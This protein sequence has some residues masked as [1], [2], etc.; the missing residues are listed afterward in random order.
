MEGIHPKRKRDKLNP[1]TLTKTNGQF[2]ISFK[3]GQGYEHTVE[4][5]E[6]IYK[7]FNEFELE[8]ISHINVISRHYEQS[9]LTE[10]TLYQRTLFKPLPIDEELAKK[11]QI[12][13]LHAAISALPDIQRKR[14]WMYYFQGLT[15]DEISKKEG[16]TIMPI[17]RSIDR[18]MIKIKKHLE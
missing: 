6:D 9:E 2:Y 11:I 8:D 10:C 16:C 3:D 5:S 13:Q 18:A 12:E 17:K 4:I 15:L 7:T 1:Y 14:L